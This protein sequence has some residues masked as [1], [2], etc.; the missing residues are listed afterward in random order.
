[1]HK[2]EIIKVLPKQF[3]YSKVGDATL[4]SFWPRHFDYQISAL[5]P[6]RHLM[7]SNYI[8]LVHECVQLKISRPSAKNVSWIENDDSWCIS[9]VGRSSY[10]QT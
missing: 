6:D 3:V 7:R 4:L 1:M 9:M 10:T 5:D 2:K 8:V